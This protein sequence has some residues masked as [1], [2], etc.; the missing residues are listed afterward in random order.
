MEIYNKLMENV[1]KFLHEPGKIDYYMGMLEKS[2][3]IKRMYIAKVGMVLFLVYMIFGY[4]AQLICNFAGFV[5]PAYV[6]IKALESPDKR[7]DT[8][9]LTYWVVFAFF[10][11]IEFFSDFIFS[12]FPFYW[13]A[14]IVFLVWCYLPTERNGSD[15]VYFNVIRPYFLKGSPGLD[16]LASRL[17]KDAKNAISKDE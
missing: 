15:Y 2:T 7:D 4:F 17:Y 16:N 11:V 6:S 1:E 12:W 3:G 14:K 13:L 5:Y 9:W 8:R 10:S